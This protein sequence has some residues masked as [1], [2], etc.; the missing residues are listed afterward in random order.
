[1]INGLI[2]HPRFRPS[3]CCSFN[4]WPSSH[5]AC[6]SSSARCHLFTFLQGK[7]AVRRATSV[8][9]LPLCSPLMPVA[10]IRDP[11]TGRKSPGEEAESAN[12]KGQ[13]PHKPRHFPRE[14]AAGGGAARHSHSYVGQQTVLGVSLC[15][16]LTQRGLLSH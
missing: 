6:G 5:S 1:M 15:C 10:S 2:P 14:G 16:L 11:T 9:L 8:F 7:D 13:D 12:P 4:L 3:P